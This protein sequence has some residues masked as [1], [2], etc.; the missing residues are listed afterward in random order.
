[1]R[2]YINIFCKNMKTNKYCIYCRKATI[3]DESSVSCINNQKKAL[4]KYAADNKLN[5]V[6]TYID[7]GLEHEGRNKM[8]E[9]ILKGQANG[10]IV[11]D[12]SRLARDASFWRQM[13]A[14]LESEIIGEIRTLASTYRND[15]YS[16]ALLTIMF[17]E[18]DYCYRKTMSDRIKKGIAAKKLRDM[19]KRSQA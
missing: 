4:E 17:A 1:M 9:S 6:G 11:F 16:K 8:M 15:S 2:A 18:R 14:L 5:V 7:T 3:Q 12:E 19:A 13:I 10:I